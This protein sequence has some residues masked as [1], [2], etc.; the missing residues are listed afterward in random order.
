MA[1]A[2]IASHSRELLANADS[3]PPPYNTTASYNAP[4]PPSN[5][6]PLAYHYDYYQQLVPKPEE[7]YHAR[8]SYP[9][10]RYTPRQ[11]GEFVCYITQAEPLDE[12]A[13]AKRQR[14]KYVMRM[15]LGCLALVAIVGL[16]SVGISKAT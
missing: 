3:Q 4:S 11:T 16:I 5:N 12:Q 1:Q 13:I 8:P 14:Q 7:V 15:Y 6:L 2:E 10:P 9:P